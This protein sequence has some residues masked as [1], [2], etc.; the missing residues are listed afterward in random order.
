MD[1]A[2]AG[3]TISLRAQDGHTLSAYA[4][5][6]DQAPRG[7][8]VLLQE[9][10][11]V[12]AHIRRVC[13]GYAAKGYHVIAPALFDRIGRDVELDYTEAGARTGRELRGK[14]SWEHTFSDIA[15]ALE[16]VSGAGKVA[17]LGYCWGGTVS[18]RS[19]VHLE[20]VAAAVCYYPT[21]ISPHAGEKPR[22][23]VLMHFGERDPIA[24]LDHAAELRAAQGAVVEMHVY[25]AS[26][27]FNCDDIAN[28][29]QPSAALAERRSLEFLR[30]HVG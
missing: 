7:G 12:T 14:I 23:P 11:G 18:W 28:F 16:H 5:R 20:G 1:E 21:Q 9:I 17:T 26:H 10:F 19:A 13:D 24:P 27:G 2:M 4:A 3:T 30:A 6:P 25:P 29:H 8:L 22:C 15:A